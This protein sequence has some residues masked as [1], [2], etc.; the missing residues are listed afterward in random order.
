MRLRNVLVSRRVTHSQ[1]LKVS[2]QL[3]QLILLDQLCLL[4]Q[5][6]NGSQCESLLQIEHVYFTDL[7]LL[8]LFLQRFV[9]G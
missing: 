4:V 2:Y 8:A 5:V 1:L 7:V 6:I 3:R 9:G